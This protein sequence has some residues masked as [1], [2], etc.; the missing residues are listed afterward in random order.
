MDSLQKKS[1]AYREIRGVDD[2]GWWIQDNQTRK[3]ILIKTWESG[4]SNCFSIVIIGRVIPSSE[5][6]EGEEVIVG[7]KMGKKPKVLK[8]AILLD[9][10][11]GMSSQIGG[12][13]VVE[14]KDDEEL[15]R[16][17]EDEYSP[18]KYPVVIPVTFKN[19][20][21]IRKALKEAESQ[22]KLRKLV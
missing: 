6:E 21:I 17:I 9:L 3:R 12:Y 2:R 11:W 15:S 18:M 7:V 4:W 1:K 19:K 13:E 20:E 14:Y 16:M 5:Q 22:K 8:K 10:Q